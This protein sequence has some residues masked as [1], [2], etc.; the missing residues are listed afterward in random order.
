MKELQ[1]EFSTKKVFGLVQAVVKIFTSAKQ[2]YQILKC[3]TVLCM[4]LFNVYCFA[5]YLTGLTFVLW[6][7]PLR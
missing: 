1:Q 7:S 6:R 3:V 2:V 5:V 4:Y